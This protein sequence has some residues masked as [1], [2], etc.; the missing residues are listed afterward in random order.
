MTGTKGHSSDFH[1][2]S[3]CTGSSVNVGQLRTNQSFRD[4]ECLEH[5]HER[6]VVENLV[7][8][9]MVK[10]VPIDPMHHFDLGTMRRLLSFLFGTK[11]D[12]KI[13]GVTLPDH[14]QVSVDAFLVSLRKYISRI[15][16]ARQPQP[17]KHLCRWK[18]TELRL[19]LHYVGVVVLKPYPPKAFYDHF[20]AEWCRKDNK[21]SKHFL[22]SFVCQSKDFMEKISYV[23][24]L[25]PCFM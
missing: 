7:Y 13:R 23:I 14:I 17:I 1:L 2:C 20:S 6:S 12:R 3:K 19:F 4:K 16:F 21:Q 5:H 24:I 22:N 10:D 11:R 18:A 9:D 25:M 8:L 15:D